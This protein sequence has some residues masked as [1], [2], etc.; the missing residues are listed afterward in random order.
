[1]SRAYEASV[2]IDGYDPKRRAAIEEAATEEWSFDDWYAQ[3][4]PLDKSKTVPT[5]S[6]SGQSQLTGGETEDEFARRLTLAI[7]K[8]NKGRCKVTVNCTCLEDLPCESYEPGDDIEDDE[9]RDKLYRVHYRDHKS[10]IEGAKELTAASED[11]A[12][13]I[14]AETTPADEILDVEQVD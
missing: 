4:G 3:K 7:F 11:D 5:L 8:A 12:R 14:F 10:K 9:F 1:M 2:Q 13:D 6:A